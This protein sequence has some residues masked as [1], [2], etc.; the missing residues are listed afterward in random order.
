MIFCTQ[1]KPGEGMSLTLHRRLRNQ[2]QWISIAEFLTSD[3]L[4]ALGLPGGLAACDVL[5]CDGRSAS[6]APGPEF[7]TPP[8]NTGVNKVRDVARVES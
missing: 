7:D 8:S 6:P 2:T 3:P 1:G 4:K 5:A